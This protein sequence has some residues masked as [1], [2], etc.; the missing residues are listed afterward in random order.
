MADGWFPYTISAEELA[1]RAD[2]IR[3]VAG[4][5]GRPERR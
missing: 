3:Q 4:D 5:A 2:L 1:E